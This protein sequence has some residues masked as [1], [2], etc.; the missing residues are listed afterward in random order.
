MDGIWQIITQK[1]HTKDKIAAATIWTLY[2][3]WARR[4]LRSTFIFTRERLPTCPQQLS[5]NRIK[6]ALYNI[7]ADPTER[8]DLS[9]KFPDIVEKLQE[10][11]QYYRSSAVASL[12]KP[13]SPKAL[14][15][16]M[17]NGVWGPWDT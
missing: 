15:T 13:L 11:M 10:R 9:K 17:K 14:E 16:A 7:T 2:Q 6:L 4:P 5:Q 1:I 12:S 8:E 3:L